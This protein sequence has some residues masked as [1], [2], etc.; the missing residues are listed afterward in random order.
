MAFYGTTLNAVKVQV[1]SAIA[2]YVPVAI[3][4]NRSEI[5]QILSICF[6]EKVNIY[7][8]LTTKS[9]K[10]ESEAPSYQLTLFNIYPEVID[11]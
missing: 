10:N 2:V 3:E 11:E 9:V 6:F 8:A 7:E 4:R 5:L 1:R